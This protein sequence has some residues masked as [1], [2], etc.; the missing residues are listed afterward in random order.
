MNIGSYR[1]LHSH[2]AR[3]SRTRLARWQTA[4]A[5]VA[6]AALW[7][8]VMTHEHSEEQR[9]EQARQLML[10]SIERNCLPH[11]EGQMV[12]VT[13]QSDGL[14]CTRYSTDSSAPGRPRV[15]LQVA[16]VEGVGP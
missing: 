7:A 9:A 14:R 2:N 15:V 11:G 3:A 5:L 8:G 16:Q 13:Y 12:V 1:T 10:A 6:V 4:G